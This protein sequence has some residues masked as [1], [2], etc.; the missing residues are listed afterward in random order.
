MA[1]DLRLQ[2]TDQKNFLKEF[3]DKQKLELKDFIKQQTIA[4][5]N[6]KNNKKLKTQQKEDKDKFV[7]KQA[8]EDKSFQEKLHKQKVED[9]E[10]LARHQ[11][12]QVISSFY[13]FPR[14]NN[15]QRSL[16]FA[17]STLTVT[18]LMHWIGAKDAREA[19]RCDEASTASARKSKGHARSGA[20]QD[21]TTATDRSLQGPQADPQATPS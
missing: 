4:L 6:D 10:M 16:H 21:D 13:Q 15:I 11:Q 2:S 17:P 7:Q 3:R 19:C 14:N 5:K 1:L 8:T 12:D 20:V 9:D 18:T